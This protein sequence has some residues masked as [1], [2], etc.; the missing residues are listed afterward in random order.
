MYKKNASKNDDFAIIWLP[1]SKGHKFIFD[2]FKQW[3]EHA[4]ISCV[5][6]YIRHYS[7][8]CN[9]FSEPQIP[10]SVVKV[11][12][13]ESAIPSIVR[14]QPMHNKIICSAHIA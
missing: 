5:I 10:V 6:N 8:G 14:E 11:Y 4:S 2:D 9:Y 12:I 1:W 13:Y 7:V 3:Q